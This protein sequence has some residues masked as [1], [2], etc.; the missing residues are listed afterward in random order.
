MTDA[1]LPLA[2]L[3]VLDFSQNLPG[4]YAT[5]L[6]TC[7]GADVVKVEPPKGDP[8]RFMEPFFS[9]VNRGKRSVVLDLR[10]PDSRPSVEALVR[11]ADV[12]V[13]GF[14]PGVMERLELDWE[15]CRALNPKLV[16]CSISAFGQDGPWRLHPGHDLNLQSL[17]GVSHLERDGS[18]AP[19]FSMLPVADLS[20]SLLAVSGIC[21]ALAKGEG[22]HLD[23]AMADGVLSWANVWGLGVDLA[24]GAKKQL[25]GGPLVEA[26]TRPLVD[27]LARAKLYAM[28]H[29]DVFRCAD[30]RWLSLGIVDEGHF[31]KALCR[32]LDLGPMAKL[33]LP[34]RI[35][36]G[37]ALKPVVARRL[38]SRPRDEWLRR[39]EEAGVPASPV[40]APEEA[41]G[42][43]QVRARGLADARGWMKSPLPGAVHPEGEAP[44][45]GEHTDEILAALTQRAPAE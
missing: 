27:F 37:P 36:A 14:R 32:E 3:K 30:D 1:S 44:R 42:H 40:L 41:A 24:A 19:R 26:I 38:R 23:V 20:S 34:A 16:Y 7:W 33:P 45:R 12:L 43:P 29:Y 15:R 18:G 21:A 9:M 11:W 2:G 28:P 39:F 31:W 10:D 17:A 8:G 13:E 22:V 4:P 5:F 6:L 35:A 25:R